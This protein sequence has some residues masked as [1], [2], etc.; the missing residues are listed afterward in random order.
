MVLARADKI[1]FVDLSDSLPNLIE[2]GYLADL[3]MTNAISI[4][5]SLINE[6]VDKSCSDMQPI[7]AKVYRLYNYEIINDALN[8][9][10]FEVATILQK[11]GYRALPIPATPSS[12]GKKLHFGYFSH[13]AAAR[14]AGLGW[15][16]PSCLLITPDLGPRLRWA[17]V[18]TD[19]PIGE[20]P[21]LIE[22]GCGN[23]SLCIKSCPAKAFTG[24]R[25]KQDEDREKRMDSMKCHEYLQK[26]D[27]EKGVRVCGIC[28]AVC[29]IGKKIA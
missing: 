23:C 25:F 20:E 29:P 26:M 19:A 8:R 11:N 2:Y 10:S 18:F 12:S 1:G 24:K 6:L 4:G 22:D 21:K 9:L 16:G 5:K 27:Q 28:I 14:L 17:T 3:K 13:K 15:I 7:T